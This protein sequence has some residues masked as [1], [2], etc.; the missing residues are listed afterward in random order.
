MGMIKPPFEDISNSHDMKTALD[1]YAFGGTYDFAVVK[2]SA[3]KNANRDS[4]ELPER[5]IEDENGNR[6]KRSVYVSEMV[7]V[8]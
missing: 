2:I 4:F 3:P 8:D 1:N 7:S 5:G 6:R